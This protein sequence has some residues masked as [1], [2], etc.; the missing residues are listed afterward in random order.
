MDTPSPSVS[1]TPVAPPRPVP[2]RASTHTPP[3]AHHPSLGSALESCFCFQGGHALACRPLPPQRTPRPVP[4][5]ASTLAPPTV[6]H[7]SLGSEL[8]PAFASYFQGGHALACR[9]LHPRSAPDRCHCG[10]APTLPQP[11]TTQP[12]LRARHVRTH[13]L[14]WAWSP[15]RN[16]TARVSKRTDDPIPRIPTT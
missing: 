7:P 2:L 5:R 16:G 14:L 4:L 8:N 11:S 6:H 15:Y 1:F 10:Q 3:T 9:L 12:W 13:L